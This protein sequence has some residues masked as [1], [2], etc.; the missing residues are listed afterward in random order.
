MES[1][2][3]INQPISFPGAAGDLL[4]ARL[5][6]PPD[7]K[8]VACA[9]FAHCFTCSKDLKPVVN[10][11]GAL[12]DQRIAVL[13]FDFTGLG[14]SGGDFGRTT[15]SSNVG[16]LVAASA[17]MEGML[18]APSILIGHSWGGTAVLR[19]AARIPSARAVVTIGSPFDPEHVEHLF[20]DELEAIEEKGKADVTVGGR[21]FSVTRQFLDDLRTHPMAEVI[22][23]LGRPL[24]IFHSPVD[25]IVGIDNAAQIYKSARHPKSFVSLDDADHL[26][27]DPVDSRF[28]GSMI[29]AWAR[30]YLDYPPEPTSPEETVRD[31]RVTTRTGSEGFRTE[32]LA[33]GHVLVSDE[34]VAVG[35]EGLGPTPYDFLA[36]ALGACTG[37]T[38]R[39]YAARKGWALREAIVRLEH[40]RLY[41]K[42]E[43]HAPDQE[44]RLDRLDREVTLIGDLDELQRRRLMEI[45]D[46]CPVH[47]TLE[48][49]VR[50][51]SREGAA[52][53]DP[54]GMLEFEAGE[55]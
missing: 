44:V 24:L 54:P 34:P 20:E 41:S 50:V 37:M 9:L 2:A 49:G 55:E 8:V 33:R 6:L 52:E 39:M 14:E 21:T 45:A 28:A 30:R 3:M 53:E 51:T 19:A 35:G 27:L 23:E 4:S 18:S 43:A 46:R 7:G 15:F 5:S 32:I 12:T 40:T 36:G 29:A 25:P 47:R 16:D 11:S 10:I 42:D 13:R 48:A 1:P 31:N 22:Q 38:L 26:L 17:Y